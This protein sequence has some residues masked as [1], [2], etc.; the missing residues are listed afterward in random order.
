MAKPKQD[1]GAAFPGH[2]NR[3]AST[4]PNA[5]AAGMSLRDYFAGQ[6]RVR[7]DNVAWE[8]LPTADTKGRMLE[9]RDAVDKR[10]A[11]WCYKQAD[12]MIAARD[13]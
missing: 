8:P 1:G 6:I 5:I 4:A 10:I 2:V 7:M 13:A 3:L 11:E 12:A 9:W